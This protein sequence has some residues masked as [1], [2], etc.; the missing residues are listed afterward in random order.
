MVVG[1]GS[2]D[3]RPFGDC[4]KDFVVPPPVASLAQS[5]GISRQN[6]VQGAWGCA[7][8]LAGWVIFFAPGLKTARGWQEVCHCTK[9]EGKPALI[10]ALEFLPG[11]RAV[12]CLVPPCPLPR[13]ASPTAFTRQS[14]SAASRTLCTTRLCLSLVSALLHLLAW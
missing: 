3:F 9:K 10:S 14:S 11:Q 5:L 7:A 6:V 13:E 8:P 2:L 12:E 1:L 4:Q